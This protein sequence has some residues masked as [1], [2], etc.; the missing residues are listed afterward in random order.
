MKKVIFACLICLLA[1]SCNKFKSVETKID[2]TENLVTY[3]A[4]NTT[5]VG[6]KQ[7]EMPNPL[8]DPIY[9]K[10]EF[11]YGYLIGQIGRA[12]Q[13]DPIK[14]NLLNKLG[15]SVT[16]K[17]YDKIIY[18]P[19]YFILED[20]IDKY[21]VKNGEDTLLGPNE[22]YFYANA[23]NVFFKHDGKWGVGPLMAEWEK[24]VV[25]N[26][27]DG[28]DIRYVVKVPGKIQWKIYDSTGKFV[29]NTTAAKVSLMEKNAKAKKY[30]DKKWGN[31]TT[32][33]IT[34]ANVKAY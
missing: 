13:K 14:W 11:K 29:K 10:V 2:G 28:K 30:A 5:M 25:L 3:T 1:V 15:K 26:Q 21:F 8:T 9:V 19:E 17:S 32:Y 24:I 6:I 4:P 22:D 16:G 20:A 27:A 23:D 34:V 33:G 7:A 31:D 12:Q 18:A